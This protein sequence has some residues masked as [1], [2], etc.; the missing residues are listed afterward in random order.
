MLAGE[1]GPVWVANARPPLLACGGVDV[2]SCPHFT[3]EELEGTGRKEAHVPELQT[4][5]SH[6]QL[7]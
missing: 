6:R 1:P 4:V 5:S 7:E 2:H 3:D